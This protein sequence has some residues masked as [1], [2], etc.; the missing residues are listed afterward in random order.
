ML[1]YS[2]SVYN[3]V[4]TFVQVTNW[5]LSQVWVVVVVQV[6]GATVCCTVIVLHHSCGCCVAL[7]VTWPLHLVREG[8]GEQM[9]THLNDLDGDNASSLSGQCGTV[10]TLSPPSPCCCCCCP[11]VPCG[12][13]AV[14]H[15][16]WWWWLL[17]RC[18]GWQEWLASMVVGRGGLLIVCSLLMPTN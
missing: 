5:T 1:Y 9:G 6:W 14:D 18:L 2:T 16:C 7:L 12:L 10:A 3:Y 13:W 4:G 15:G 17:V 11:C 8:D